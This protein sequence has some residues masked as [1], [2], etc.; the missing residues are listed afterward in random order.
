MSP[1]QR[2]EVAGNGNARGKY[3]SHAKPPRR[4]GNPKF[5][6]SD[7]KSG[8]TLRLGGFA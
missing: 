4:K 6:I 7:L 1:T 8:I 2:R 3:E 5:E